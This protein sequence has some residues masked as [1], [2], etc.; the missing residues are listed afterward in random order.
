MTKEIRPIIKK[1][2]DPSKV[3]VFLT[4]S[5]FARVIPNAMSTEN[6]ATTLRTA[7]HNPWFS[8]LWVS[9][10]CAVGLPS[11]PQDR[12]EMIVHFGRVLQQSEVCDNNTLGWMRQFGTTLAVEHRKGNIEPLMEDAVVID[13]DRKEITFMNGTPTNIPLPV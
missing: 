13:P 3:G 9:R 1:P 12:D 5:P 2:D 11:L 6:L 7:L 10:Q 8:A 4:S